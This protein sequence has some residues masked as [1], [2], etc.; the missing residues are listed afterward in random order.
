ML[1][2]PVCA[3]S[4]AAHMTSLL[5]TTTSIAVTAR[6]SAIWGR[7]GEVQNQ[8]APDALCA[9]KSESPRLR[10]AFFRQRAATL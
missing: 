8:S 10:R 1:T 2:P 4:T 7:R 3:A 9:I 6:S 5:E